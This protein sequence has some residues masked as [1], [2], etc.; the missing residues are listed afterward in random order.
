M[1][2]I[3]FFLTFSFFL[4]TTVN[5]QQADS[6][7]YHK[8]E[9]KKFYK[10]GLFKAVIVPSVLIGYGV[11]TIHGNGFYS[12]YDAY[13]DIHKI[14]F[15]AT[16]IDDYLQYAPY[17]EL[18][19]LNVFQIKCKNDFINT[20]LLIVKSEILMNA[21]V[22]PLK[23]LTH[24]TRPDSVNPAR[25]RSFPS[26]HTANAF[27]AA[28][29]V[30]K[31]YKH[32]SIWYGV[33][34]YTIAVSV[35]ALRMLNNRHWEADVF[36]GAGFG[37]LSVHLAYLTHRYKWGRKCDITLLPTYRNGNMGLCFLKKF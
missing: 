18:A 15:K 25:D 1:K 32:K 2:R 34:A 26:G 28:S 6:L 14:N 24:I 11:S 23:T 16:H 4:V 20:A 33:G 31:E 35:G 7:G 19:L 37:M 17:A 8:K 13:R 22:F 9:R 36:A 27:L 21:I 3:Y 12:S 30:H 29:I 5:A 10:T